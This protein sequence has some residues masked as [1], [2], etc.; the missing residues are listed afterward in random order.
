MTPARWDGDGF[1]VLN[2]FRKRA[3][4]DFVVGEVYN[5]E[6]VEQRSAKSHRFYFAALTEAWRNLPEHMADQF[7]NPEAL[8]KWALIKAGYC[9]ERSIVCASKAEAHRVAAFVG[10]MDE[11]AVVTVSEAVV[12]VYTAKSQSMRAMGGKVF[13]ES[14]QRVLDIVSGLIG[15]TSVALTSQA[16]NAA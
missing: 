2:S 11:F 14:K 12:S 15:T 4:Q 13:N 8:R 3:D 5:L 10:P 6:V 9:D 7:P 1:V 16:E